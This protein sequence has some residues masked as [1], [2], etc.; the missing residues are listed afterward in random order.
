M[1]ICE[2]S[3]PVCFEGEELQIKKQNI[4]QFTTCNS[5]YS[6]VM[7]YPF[8]ITHSVACFQNDL[9]RCSYVLAQ[10]LDCGSITGDWFG[11][12]G[13][14]PAGQVTG[15]NHC[16]ITDQETFTLLLLVLNTYNNIFYC[17]ICIFQGLHLSIIFPT[18]PPILQR[19]RIL[20]VAICPRY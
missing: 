15:C 7:S 8:H 14:S 13:L 12:V 11:P 3:N 2:Y 16:V 20:G 5:I 6:H 1:K 4:I 10:E 17:C 18:G 9:S 19:L